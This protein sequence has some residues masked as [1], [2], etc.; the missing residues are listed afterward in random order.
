[1]EMEEDFETVE[2]VKEDAVG[3]ALTL[4]TL[5]L[6]EAKGLLDAETLLEV[7]EVVV[8]GRMKPAILVVKSVA[9]LTK[10]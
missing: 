9:V 2:V 10:S 4:T 6:L 7:V 3:D 8:A 5:E 1:M